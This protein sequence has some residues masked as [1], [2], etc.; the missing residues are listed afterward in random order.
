MTR[1]R[2]Y[3][4]GD[5]PAARPLMGDASPD[6]FIAC[7]LLRPTRT[8]RTVTPGKGGAEAVDLDRNLS[9]R[10]RDRVRRVRIVGKPDEAEVVSE[11]DTRDAVQVLVAAV[12]LA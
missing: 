11:E 1:I 5:Q 12:L 6:A 9:L 4:T 7:V 10:G 8:V 3:V 2:H